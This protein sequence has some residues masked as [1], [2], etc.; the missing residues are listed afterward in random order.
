MSAG[1]FPMAVCMQ[2]AQERRLPRGSVDLR[3]ARNPLP[4]SQVRCRLLC[5]PA[6]ASAILEPR[7]NNVQLF[8][9]IIGFMHPT[10]SSGAP[11]E[12]S[13]SLHQYKKLKDKLTLKLGNLAAEA[14]R[15]A[16]DERWCQQYAL[17]NKIE[18][19][20]VYAALSEVDSQYT[21]VLSGQRTPGEQ[22]D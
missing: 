7:L 2:R 20:A 14:A 9:P 3:G 22:D 12:P 4:R 21:P 5:T 11:D 10:G 6:G 16:T 19:G 1:L 8:H 13:S 17:S 15:M 18:Q